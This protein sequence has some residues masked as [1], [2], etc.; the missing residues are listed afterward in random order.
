[1]KN[2]LLS[3][4]LTLCMVLQFMPISAHAAQSDSMSALDMQEISKTEYRISPDI[5][6]YE[7]LLNNSQLSNQMVGHVMEV[8]LSEGS[9]ASLATGYSDYNIENIKNGSWAMV[10]TT[11]QAQAMES[12]RE[13]NVVGAVNGGGFDM[14]NGRPTGALVLN[15]TVIQNATGTTFWVDMDGKAHITNAAE[16]QQAVTAG[17][18]KEALSSFGDILRDGRA[19]TNL[20]NYTRASRTAVGIKADGTVVIFMVDGRQAPYSTGM[21]MAE[22]A[23][24]ME[25]LDC[26]IAI[27]LDGGGSS[28]F[29]TQREGDVVAEVDPKGETGGLTVRCRPSDGYERKVSN[30][31]MVLS[32][33]KPTGEFDHAA[34]TPNNALYT[35]GSTITFEASGVDESGYPAT[36]PADASWSVTEGASLGTI[37]ASTGVFTAAA[38][39]QGV[40]KV[41][42]SSGGRV[43][44]TTQI[45]LRWPDTLGFTN[46]SVSL[47]FGQTSDLTFKPTYQGREVNY[48]DGDFVWSLDETQPI[49]YK[50]TALVETKAWNNGWMDRN[51]YMSLVGAV[52][53]QQE[54]NWGQYETRTYYTYF[55]EQ[56]RTFS[57]LNDGS[58]SVYEVLT[59]D[60]AQKMNG[61]QAGWLTEEELLDRV[62]TEFTFT[63]GK[64]ANNQF[65]ADEDNSLR[66]TMKVALR[67]NAGITGEVDLVVGMDPYV[68]MDF[69]SKTAGGNTVSGEAYWKCHVGSSTG[70][71]GNS[72]LTAD[73]VK[74]SRLWIRDTTGKGVV[75][76]T[77]YNAVVSAEEDSNVRFGKYAFR[78]G[79][80]FSH[81]ALSSVA[82]ADFGF[83]GDML[84]NTVQPTKIGMWVNVPSNLKSDDSILKAVMKGNASVNTATATAYMTLKEDG[85]TEYANGELAGT[86][87]YVQYYSYNADGTVSGSK[88]SDW[89]GK[90]W[91]WVEADISSFQMPLDMCRAYTVRVTSPQN[92]TKGTGYIYIDNLQFIYGTNTNDITNPVIETVTETGSG[93]V[94]YADEMPELT[95]TTDGKLNF[96]INYSDSEQ[97]DK[98]ATGVDTGACRVYVDETDYTDQLDIEGTTMYLTGLELRNGTHTLTVYLKDFYGNETQRDYTFVLSDPRGSEAGIALVPQESAPEIGK[99]FALYIVNVTDE[100]ILDAELE[101]ELPE[102]YLTNVRLEPFAGYSGEVEVKNGRVHVRL[103]NTAHSST[104]L[105]SDETVEYAHEMACLLLKVPEATSSS[106]VLRYT[107]KKGVY[108]TLGEDGQPVANTFSGTQQSV[109]LQAAYQLEIGRV[110]VGEKTTLKVTDENGN[111]V[112]R[113][114]VYAGETQIGA[115]GPRGTLDHTFNTAGLTTIYAEKDGNRTWNTNVVVCAKPV[116]D[117][118]KPFGVLNNA[119]ENASTTQSITWLTSIDSSK[120]KA[121]VKYSTQEDMS[122]AQQKE[123]TSELR[124]FVEAMQGSA[125]R[126]GTVH[127]TGLTP[128]TTY[129]YQVGDGETWS[130]T[131]QLKTA[132]TAGKTTSFF[133]LG[134]IQTSDTSR[135]STALEKLKD[136][137][138]DFGVQTGDAIDNV[139]VFT[140]WQAFFTAVNGETLNGVSL[141]HVL[142]NHEYYGDADG[143]ISGAIYDLPKSAQND[144]YAVEYGNVCVVTVNH[145]TDLVGAA[146]EIAEQLETSCPWKILVTHEPIYGTTEQLAQDKLT[147]ITT[148]LETAGIDFVFGGDHHSYARTYPMLGNVKQEESSRAGIVYYISG[149]LSSKS[150]KFTQQDAHAF[151]KE[152]ND[153]QG[154]YLTAEATN[155]TMTIK[156]YKYDG[157][158]I[159]TYT[160]TRTNCELGRH[161]ADS[162][163]K[164]D[165]S[166]DTVSCALCDAAFSAKDSGYNG[167]LSTTD[168]KQVILAAG[169]LKKD[170]FTQV[171]DKM[172]HSCA[173]GYA[174][175]TKTTTTLTCVKGGHETYTCPTCS[176]TQSSEFLYPNGHDWNDQH[177]CTTCGFEGINIAD[178]SKV[179]FRFE[180][181][182][183][184]EPRYYYQP[185]GV[186]PTSSGKHGDHVLTTTNDANLTNEAE[187]RDAYVYWPD[188]KDIGKARII[189]EGRG[190]YYGEATLTY[191]IVPNDVK[192]VSVSQVTETGAKLSWAAAAG[193]QY[194]DVYECDATNSKRIKYVGATTTCEFTLTD[195]APESQHYY[196]VAGRAKAATENDEVYNSPR[197]SSIAS[198][199]TNP[200]SADVTGMSVTVDGVEIAA[201][202]EG[203]SNYLFLPATADLTQLPVSVTRSEAQGKLVIKGDLGETTPVTGTETTIDLTKLASESDGVRT[204][205]LT[206]GVGRSM[207]VKVMQGSGI[208]T[209]YL[210]SGT[211]GE[212]RAWVDASKSNVT[213]GSMKLLAADGKS[214]YDGELKQIKAR[215]NSTFAHTDK[216]SYQ[217]KL[218]EKSDLLGNGE[219]VKTWVLLANYF[220]ATLMHDKLLK[221]LATELGMPYVASCDWVN[222]Y[223][224]GEYRGVYLLSEKNALN[225][226]SVNIT[227]LEALYEQ[228]NENYGTDMT[229]ASGTN[230]YGQSFAYTTGLIDPD[231]LTGG[232]LLEVN[233]SSWD[234]V[235]GFKT[236]KNVGVNLKSP[237]YSGEAALQYISEYY[238][239]FEDAVYATDEDGNYTGVNPTTGK[240]FDEYV[241]MDS[242]VKTFL[243]QE[244]AVN[245]DGFISSLY[246]YKDANGKM[247]AGPIWDQD[248]T[249]GTGWAK[250][251]AP[252]VNYQYHYLAEALIQIPKFRD[253]VNEY[254]NDTFAPE[255]ES[256]LSSNGLISEQYELLADNAE[257]NYVLWPYVRVG[258]PQS[259]SHIWSG[260]SYSMVVSDLRSWISSRLTTLNAVF[261]EE[262]WAAGDINKDGAI[263]SSDA[264]SILRWLAGYQDAGVDPTYGDFDGNGT[265]NSSDAVAIL[266]HLAGYTN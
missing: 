170:A 42:L 27:N 114:K 95:S 173:D 154:L 67:A 144:W 93:T 256:W 102:Q 140:N 13:V 142:G 210:T 134:D 224:D 185:G 31:L 186:R 121:I 258:D 169:V 112:S 34:L 71:G 115:T 253:A 50:Y 96:S 143:E 24:A 81:I 254:Y 100:V 92:C 1:M 20:D 16:Y 149:D 216:K 15:G 232:Y 79:Y 36:L 172:Y 133:V 188:N 78:L 33:A 116:V 56:S 164:Y 127:L 53:V 3:I 166:G 66:A 23:A 57:Y 262:T 238:Q 77:G 117:E 239:E 123:G 45:E 65:I 2:R 46:T 245:P 122:D 266:R 174:Y 209:L 261:P 255:V 225:S 198:V 263:N 76:P 28:T 192:T 11:A 217:I 126:G 82:S 38:D 43:V 203:N 252:D 146:Q 200:P 41:A 246:F 168:G 86:T 247:Y 119:V 99:D 208:P 139:T 61:A 51:L 157:T 241:D 85:T 128:D 213:S 237:E 212:T 145:G 125:L 132:V 104:A 83:S 118:G 6:E 110:I 72:Y 242:L 108:S 191:Y 124:F 244:L 153:Y 156:A 63:I 179:V 248:M 226:T 161:T 215:G 91:L 264:V 236:K 211:D 62:N 14:S 64:I 162:T 223:Y 98:Y 73:E 55:T 151:A 105:T 221:D 204:I 52:G 147:A 74:T 129:Y 60:K 176:K 94:L 260:A 205:T 227:D 8:D 158:L 167:L 44:G 59:H 177:V 259:S 109:T 68:L 48:K 84:V 137:S 47:D 80:D 90:G 171:V 89:A 180:G 70:A 235:N 202:S 165:M 183:S 39:A 206:I 152:H 201:V 159:D 25:G 190:N 250:Y 249:F 195:L 229:T 26:E 214:T 231:D 69:E 196:V 184:K 18:V 148:A 220:D 120:A 207:T 138:Y 97:K 131:Y 233:H 130:E 29:A 12:R 17:N 141:F 49:R 88:L 163:S 19:L 4:V 103:A 32:S 9:K 234:E 150:N 113:A 21:T 197:W 193:A 107:L 101:I 181:T 182:D 230:K 7:W 160:E 22:L 155:E 111:S 75:F 5:K 54:I 219:S 218:A 175:E 87:S 37:D 251:L 189:Y 30:T 228:R 10:T 265:V 222:L 136:G 135:L 58:I 240:S 243:L 199:K 40:V 35:P 178:T 194:Y 106:D 257:M 187:M